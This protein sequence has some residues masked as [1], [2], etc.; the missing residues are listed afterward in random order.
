MAELVILTKYTQLMQTG[1]KGGYVETR[2]SEHLFGAGDT[3][4]INQSWPHQRGFLSEP[5]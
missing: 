2:V 3:L 5:G 1:F 4:V